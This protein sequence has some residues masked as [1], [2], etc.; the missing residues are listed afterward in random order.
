[1]PRG[2]LKLPGNK[3]LDTGTS[4][5]AIFGYLAHFCV[6]DLPGYSDVEEIFQFFFVEMTKKGHPPGSKY[7]LLTMA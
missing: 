5:I 6:K 4:V 7:G 1:M 2:H 3:I